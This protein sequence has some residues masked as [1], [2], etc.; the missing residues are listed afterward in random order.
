MAGNKEAAEF[1]DSIIA[2]EDDITEIKD[3]IKAAVEAF[4]SSNGVTPEGV[5]R[6]IKD[7]KAFLKDKAKFLIT[8]RDAEKIFD[9]MN[10][11]PQG[12]LFDQMG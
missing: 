1:Y 10:Y 5:A 7:R 11:D 9:L 8:D 3:E 12:D 2:R 4:A 6:A